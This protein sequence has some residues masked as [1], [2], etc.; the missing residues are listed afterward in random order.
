MLADHRTMDNDAITR[1]LGAWQ[2]GDKEALDEL[3]PYVYAELQK[4]AVSHM[5]RERGSHTLQSTALVHEAF[6]KLVDADVDFA[7]RAHFYGVASRIMRRVLV[8]HA[9]SAGRQKRGGDVQRV[10]L[11][12]AAVGGDLS[13]D[14]V[15]LDE[16]LNKLAEFDAR[17]AGAV[18][19]VFFGGLKHDEAAEVL[20]VSRT[21]L[22][23][24]MKLAKA[25]LKREMG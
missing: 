2:S 12:E 18:E 24:D 3:T 1:L 6:I 7:S 4:L 23:E 17:M 14:V 25:W 8:D 22:F 5:R 21:T 15:E 9:R 20:G 11:H 16:A 10:T 19:L 13:S